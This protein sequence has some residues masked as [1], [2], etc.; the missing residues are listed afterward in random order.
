M[1]SSLKIT[2]REFAIGTG[3]IA[4]T[5]IAAVKASFS[6]FDFAGPAQAQD[7]SPAELM[8]PGPLGDMILGNE[9]APVT[10]IE[11]ASMTCPHCAN[12]HET[13]YPE[14]KKRYIDTG[15]VRFIFR[16]FPLDQLAAAG[17]MLARCG[18]QDASK[19]GP[20]D[21]GKYFAMV[22]TLFAQQR[23]WVVQRPLQ[24]LLSIAKQAGFS[25][26]SFNECLKNQQVL[27]GIEAVR[28][29]AAQQFNVQSTPTFFINGKLMRGAMTIEEFDK[30]LAPYLKD[31]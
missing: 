25:E 14:L 21:P 27:E 2:R 4:L 30:Q 13:T 26:Q 3:A 22:E 16:E 7:A 29:R 17:F 15:K 10:I 9:K 19:A 11:Y 8:Q 23:E 31:G 18:T 6:G 28:T 24:P 1:E 5:G 12:F 20:T